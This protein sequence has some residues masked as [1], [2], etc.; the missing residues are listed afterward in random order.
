MMMT[1]RYLGSSLWTALL[2]PGVELAPVHARTISATLHVR[3]RWS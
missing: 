2:L 1:M 3:A